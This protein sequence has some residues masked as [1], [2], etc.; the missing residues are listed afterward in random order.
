MSLSRVH[1]RR[2]RVLRTRVPAWD[3]SRGRARRSRCTAQAAPDDWERTIVR[4]CQ[5]GMSAPWE[6]SARGWEKERTS[7]RVSVLRQSQHEA[8]Y[9]PGRIKQRFLVA[10]QVHLGQHLLLRREE[11][12][13]QSQGHAGHRPC[14]GRR[15][16]RPLQCNAPCQRPLRKSDARA[17]KS[18][19]ATA[20]RAPG[21]S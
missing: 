6:H 16:L 21:G 18:R 13:C 2:C 4:R 11:K 10:P 15:A 8:T 14:P 17:G 9:P 12:V 1:S 3:T 19:S 20:I 7:R 5:R